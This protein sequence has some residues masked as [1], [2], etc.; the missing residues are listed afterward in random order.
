MAIEASPAS[1]RLGAEEAAR[2]VVVHVEF[3]R[4]SVV[5]SDCI[6]ITICARMRLRFAVLTKCVQRQFDHVSSIAVQVLA[7]APWLAA[8]LAE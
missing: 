3:W 6:S 7:V 5:Y 4:G 1:S 8:C 2:G